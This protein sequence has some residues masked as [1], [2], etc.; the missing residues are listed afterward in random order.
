MKSPAELIHLDPSFFEVRIEVY[1]FAREFITLK[2]EINPL[3]SIARGHSA[4]GIFAIPLS[5]AC[6]TPLGEI[7]QQVLKLRIIFKY[8]PE[9]GKSFGIIIK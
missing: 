5:T 1:L 8:R 7:L 3:L 4:I 9:F 2:T 6:A